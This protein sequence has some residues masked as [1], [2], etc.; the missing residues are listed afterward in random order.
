MH[1]PVTS[2]ELARPLEIPQGL[3]QSLADRD[4]SCS[5]LGGKDLSLLDREPKAG[6]LVSRGQQDDII[7]TAVRDGKRDAAGFQ[8]CQ[9]WLC[10]LPIPLSMHIFD[11]A[12]SPLSGSPE[13]KAGCQWSVI[14]FPNISLMSLG[15]YQKNPLNP[16]STEQ[17]TPP[18]PQF[19]S[20]INL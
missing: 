5:C 6:S 7:I 3:C 11:M 17:N 16:K 1:L 15:F 12:A 19:N 18:P 10:V 13:G 4:C 20:F 14:T 8:P 9:V 2:L